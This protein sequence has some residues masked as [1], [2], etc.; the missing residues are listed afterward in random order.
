MTTVRWPPPYGKRPHPL[1]APHRRGVRPDQWPTTG[2][3]GS[4]WPPPSELAAPPRLLE[5]SRR[6]RKPMWAWGTRTKVLG[7][8]AVASVATFAGLLLVV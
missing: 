2:V 4:V 5:W 3:V 8:L 1:P 7:G 6:S